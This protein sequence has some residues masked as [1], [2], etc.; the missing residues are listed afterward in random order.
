MVDAADVA[1]QLLS[2]AGVVAAFDDFVIS[3]PDLVSIP[4]G[5]YDAIC[6][7]CRKEHR[8]KRDLLA[9]KFK[10]AAHGA[11]FGQVLDGYVNLDFGRGKSRAVPT[12]SKLARWLRVIALFDQTVST[13]HFR[14]S[15]FANYLFVVRV[16][17]SDTDHVQESCD[18][19]PRVTDIVGVVGRLGRPL[20]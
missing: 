13:K 10:I 17:P 18:L 11:Y 3:T 5:D 1:S 15:T 16:E 2:G 12:R 4:A 20:Q 7:S 14:L 8:F 9:F 19:V 6:I